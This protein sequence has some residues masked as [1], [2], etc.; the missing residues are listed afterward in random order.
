MALS[1]LNEI[2]EQN[3]QQNCKFLGDFF[4]KKLGT[5]RSKYEIVGDVRGKGLMIGIEFVKDKLSKKPLAVGD[6]AKIRQN[7]LK[8]GVI[9]GGGGLFMNVIRIVPPMCVT[10]QDLI[11]AFEAIDAGIAEFLAE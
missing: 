1:V 11:G 6:M 10:E 9:V 5:L 2:E 3:L 7:C 4:T 8:R